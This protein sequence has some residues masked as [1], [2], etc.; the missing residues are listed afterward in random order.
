MG[1]KINW[2]MWHNSPRCLI[3]SLSIKRSKKVHFDMHFG[4]WCISLTT[5]GASYFFSC[6]VLVLCWCS[7][8]K[9]QTKHELRQIDLKTNHLCP[10]LSGW[11]GARRTLHGPLLDVWTNPFKAISSITRPPCDRV[12][13]LIYLQ[14]ETLK[15][16]TL[17]F[18]IVTLI[19]P[20]NLMDTQNQVSRLH[21][22]SSSENN[23][24]LEMQMN[25]DSG[26][27]FSPFFFRRELLSQSNPQS[28]FCIPIGRVLVLGACASRW[29]LKVQFSVSAIFFFSSSFSFLFWGGASCCFWHYDLT[30]CW[31]YNLKVTLEVCS[32]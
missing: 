21:S 20:L 3:L 24:H 18:T 19:T 32:C 14:D 27:F 28:S 16:R 1:P 30:G 25:F 10:V 12:E 26:V 6:K 22:K 23:P 15:P 2:D 17:C 8:S 9:D 13:L 11:A 7:S 4:C 29:A 5:R 31:A